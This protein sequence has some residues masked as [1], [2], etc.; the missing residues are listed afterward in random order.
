[1]EFL[2]VLTLFPVVII[3]LCSSLRSLIANESLNDDNQMVL[4][5]ISCRDSRAH[6]VEMKLTR[7]IIIQTSFL[8][9]APTFRTFV[10]NNLFQTCMDFS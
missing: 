5:K 1:M 2:C 8:I 6:G 7:T 10:M 4:V 3:F 9:A